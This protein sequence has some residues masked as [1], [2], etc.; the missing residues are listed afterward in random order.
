MEYCVLHP[1]S[2][3]RNWLVVL[4]LNVPV[5]NFSVMSGRSHRF[6]GNLPVLSGSK[7]SCSRTQHGGGI[8]GI[9]RG[10]PN[11]TQSLVVTLPKKG[12]L[13]LCQNY[14]PISLISQTNKVMLKIILN[15]LQ[16]QAEEFIAEEQTGFRARRSTREQIF[17]LRIL[18]EKYLQHQQNLYHVFTDFKNAFDRVW[19]EALWQLWG[20]KTSTPASYEPLKICMTR[21]RVQSCSMAAQENGSELQYEFNKG[22]YSHQPS[23]T[24]FLERI[25]CEALD[26]HEGSVSIRGPLITNFRFAD[27]IVIK[28]KDE[29]KAGVLLER[30]GTTTTRYKMEIGPDKTKVMKNNPNGFQREIKI[31]GQ[32]LEE[33]ENFKYLGTIISNEGSKPEIL[34]RIAQITAALSR[35][36]YLACF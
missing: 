3:S 32:R 33:V 17:N 24:I 15:R 31:K 25:M 10:V 9:G 7:V 29:E 13:Q 21:P 6:L 26:D 28:A 18:G 30:L 1:R 5:N 35:Q 4:R 11:G 19:H 36:E 23:F 2:D 16:Q 20:N 22:V 8:H 12:N 14:R 34:S 27:D